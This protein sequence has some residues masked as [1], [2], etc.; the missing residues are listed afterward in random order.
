MIDEVAIYGKA[1]SPGII[2][3]HYQNGLNGHGYDYAD[4]LFADAA[5]GDYHLA[6]EGWRWS[7]GGNWTWDDVTS[8]CIDVGNPGAPLGD[9]LLVVSRD[10]D[11]YWGENVRVNIGAYGRTAYASMAPPGWALLADLYNDGTVDALDL[12]GQLR[13]WLTSGNEL[14][15]DVSWDGAVDIKDFGLLTQDWLKE[16]TWH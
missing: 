12:A 13:Y 6:S 9:E 8:K 5:G 2:Q 4:P 1:L 15:G 7:P 3:Q 11:N 10:P 14:P 16:T